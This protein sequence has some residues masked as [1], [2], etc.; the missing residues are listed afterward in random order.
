MADLGVEGKIARRMNPRATQ[1]KSA[2]ADWLGGLGR[3]VL[4][5]WAAGWRGWGGIGLCVGLGM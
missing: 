1:A 5:G 3:S 2:F 4:G